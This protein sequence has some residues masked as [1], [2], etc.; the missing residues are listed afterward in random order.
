MITSSNFLLH[1]LKIIPRPAKASFQSQQANC[2]FELGTSFSHKIVIELKSDLRMGR[3]PS[4][5]RRDGRDGRDRDRDRSDRDR[6]RERERDK[7][8]D[9]RRSRSPRDRE[10]RRSRERDDD[11]PSQAADSQDESSLLKKR[12]PISIEERLKELKESK[13]ASTKPVFLTKEQRQKLAL[14]KLEEKRLEVAKQREQIFQSAR[15]DRDS[16]DTRD[17][18]RRDKYDKDPVTE[19][20]KAQ[21]NEQEVLITDKE[22]QGIKGRYLGEGKKKKKV[23][24]MSDKFRFAFDWELAEDTSK[25]L[26]PLYNKKHDAQLLFGRGLRAGIDMREQKKNST[27]VEQLE[28]VRAKMQERVNQENDD[29]DIVDDEKERLLE[30]QRLIEEEERR[31]MVCIT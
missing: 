14:E 27:Y 8:R 19:P 31:R 10:R 18:D 16:R 22:M 2:H 25:D 26:N 13:E 21:S 3:S 20:A 17:R 29:M 15:S 6:D 24:K 5:S 11:K 9:R 12:E 23:I 1:D 28:S 7:D 4:P 30:E